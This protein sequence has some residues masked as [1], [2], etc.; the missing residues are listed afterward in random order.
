MRSD[1]GSTLVEAALV[2]PLILVLIFG[3]VEFGRYITITSTVTNASRE[4]SRYAA[5]TGPGSGSGP[6]YADCDG[7]RDAAQQFG[8]LGKPTDGQID[9]QYDDGTGTIIETCNGKSELAA[10]SVIETGDRIISTVTIPYQPI[11][12][13]IGIFLG[14]TNIEVQT[15]R[16]IN[17]GP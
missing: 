11:L 17:K 13:L 4:A 3:L 2:V 1:R 16:T 5:G 15:I 6:R 14:P 9:L 10:P 12:P 7:M 8:V